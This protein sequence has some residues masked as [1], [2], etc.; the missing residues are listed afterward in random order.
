MIYDGT[1]KQRDELHRMIWSV[2][3]L[4]L[5]LVGFT[6]PET[7]AT[8][9][10]H[11]P[12]QYIGGSESS[13]WI[14]FEIY[15]GKHLY[16]PAIVNGHQVTALLDSGASLV[17]LN[18]P[19]AAVL[20]IRPEGSSD[21]IG[22]GGTGTS[23]VAHDVRITVGRLNI[24]AQQA[25]IVDETEVD[26]RIGHS[27]DIALGGEI[28]QK[29]VVDIDFEHKRLEILNP[30]G[31]KAPPHAQV[32]SLYAAGDV[33]AVDATVENRSA[34]MLFDLGNG[35]AVYLH[36]RFWDRPDFL[37]G[38]RLSSGFSGGWTGASSQ[39]IAMLRSLRIG[40]A[41]FENVPVILR[42]SATGGPDDIDGNI[43]LPVWSRF[44][45][46]VDFSHNRLILAPP[47]DLVTPFSVNH[48]GLALKQSGRGVEVVHVASGS[49]GEAAHLTAGDV[50][51]SVRDTASGENVPLSSN[52]T[53]AQVN[54][55]FLILLADGRVMQLTTAQYY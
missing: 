25:V 33:R 40:S 1:R 30:D 32:L 15:Q 39:K 42:N 8:E 18:A 44:H 47:V 20:G 3:L 51:T 48:T 24:H 27:Q 7:F 26:K 12:M 17:V 50:I 46:I 14:P 52:W 4:I 22:V 23:R 36:P 21:A 53:N 49:P 16:F 6:A 37:A 2:E 5:L 11:S 31:F 29:A 55:N 9:T 41:A 45:L 13:G 54:I 10:M 43:G 28:F 35:G 19:S 34:R 38:R